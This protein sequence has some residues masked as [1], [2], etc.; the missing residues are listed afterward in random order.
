MAQS[1]SCF[2]QVIDCE[3]KFC[4]KQTSKQKKQPQT[5]KKINRILVVFGGPMK[6]SKGRKRRRRLELLNLKRK[7]KY[8]I[9]SFGPQSCMMRQYMNDISS[10]RSECHKLATHT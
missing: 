10:I 9:I 6:D 4:P 5:A 3:N 2:D 7:I 1:A 8:Q